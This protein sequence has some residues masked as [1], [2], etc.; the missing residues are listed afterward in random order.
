MKN[1]RLPPTD[2]AN[3]LFRDHAIKRSR[4]L[5]LIEPKVIPYTYNPF[6]RT[7]GDAVN[8]QFELLGYEMLPTPW[9]TL[10]QEVIRACKGRESLIAVNMPVARATHVHALEQNIAASQID[11]SSLRLA[12]GQSY[13]FWMPLLL[14]SNGRFFVTYPEPR[15]K[16][17]LTPL[18]MQVAMSVQHE[19]FRALGSDL[20]EIGLQVWRYANT[21]DRRIIVYTDE[22]VELIPYAA[23]EAETTDIYNMLARLLAERE[24]E[25]KR[26]AYGRRGPLI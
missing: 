13:S 21:D 5:D 23:L 18:G 16:G 22:G 26:S 10:E 9:K 24:D 12:P 6:R 7:V 8:L 17:H 1:Y 19:R 15:R 3:I 14:E 4:L 20:A 2:L 11:A 25:L